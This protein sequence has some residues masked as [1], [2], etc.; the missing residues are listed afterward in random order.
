MKTYRDSGTVLSHGGGGQRVGGSVTVSSWRTVSQGI[1]IRVGDA[2]VAEADFFTT[3]ESRVD[4]GVE[5]IRIV[6]GQVNDGI[7]RGRG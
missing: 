1:G 5:R 7:L 6:A 2:G 4:R 3:S